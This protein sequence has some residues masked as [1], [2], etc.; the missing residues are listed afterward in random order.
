MARYGIGASKAC[1]VT[2]GDGG[3]PLWRGEDAGDAREPAAARLASERHATSQIRRSDDLAR[4]ATVGWRGE[5]LPGRGAV[6]VSFLRTRA[7]GAVA[8]GGDVADSV[9]GRRLQGRGSLW[10]RAATLRTASVDVVFRVGG[11]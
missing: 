4:I 9:G 3:P 2:V 7:G 5:A 1:G 10:S 8:T 6:R 11:R